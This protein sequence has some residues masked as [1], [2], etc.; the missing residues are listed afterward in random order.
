MEADG[1]HLRASLPVFRRIASPAGDNAGLVMVIPEQR[2]PGNALQSLLP[3]GQNLLQLRKLQLLCGPLAGD[4]IAVHAHM[5]KLEAHGEL[6]SLQVPVLFCLLQG[7]PGA[8]S[9]RHQ[10]VF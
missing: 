9:H 6:C 3:A 2:I 10:I 1:Q 8:L 4:R 5:L 7:Y